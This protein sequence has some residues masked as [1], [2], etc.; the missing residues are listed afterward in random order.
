MQNHLIIRWIEL[1]AM[2]VPLHG[3]PVHC[4][5]TGPPQLPDAQLRTKKIGACIAVVLP[6]RLQPNSFTRL[7]MP[8]PRPHQ[9]VVPYEMHDRLVHDANLPAPMQFAKSI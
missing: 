6:R 1:V 5:R 9:P 3:M 7:G 2:T 4:H 8:C